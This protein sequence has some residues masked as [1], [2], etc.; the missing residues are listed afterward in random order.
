MVLLEPL[1]L[2]EVW[3]SCEPFELPGIPPATACTFASAPAAFSTGEVL[4]VEEV[5][6]TACEEELDDEMALLAFQL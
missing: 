6:G 2:T 3:V 5:A 4:D 1:P